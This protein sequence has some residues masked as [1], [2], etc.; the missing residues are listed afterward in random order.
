[1]EANRPHRDEAYEI[2]LQGI[3]AYRLK[4]PR[5]APSHFDANGG[6][7]DAA[8]WLAGYDNERDEQR[9][10]IRWCEALNA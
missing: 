7:S 3:D 5:R 10:L 9:L 6:D 8:L 4:Q 1:M 2:F